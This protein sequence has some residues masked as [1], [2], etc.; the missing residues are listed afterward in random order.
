[1]TNISSEQRGQSIQAMFAHI[2]PYYDRMNR[3]MT[4]GQDVRWRQEVIRRAGLSPGER[5]LDLGAGTGDLAAE[6]LRQYPRSQ[7]IAADF[8]VE[9]MHTGRARGEVDLT[10]SA[11][12]ALCLPFPTGSFDAVVSG[13]LLRNVGNIPQALAEQRRV[14]KTGGRLIALDT[15]RPRRGLLSPLIN[16]HLHTIIPAMG[17]LLT[18]DAEAY[19]YLPV[20]TQSFLSAEQLAV[21]LVRA[22]FHQVGFRRL[23][24]G[25]MAIHW[26]VK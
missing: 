1:M 9:M 20:S 23:M 11:A 8:T 12:D 14:L 22:G 13:Y 6:A 25:T 21:R 17:R 2:A 10:W 18:G 7:V 19:T 16:L 26:G 3:L 15:T 24:F 5:L 4:A